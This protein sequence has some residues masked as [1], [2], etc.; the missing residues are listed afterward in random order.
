MGFRIK[1]KERVDAAVRRIVRAQLRRGDPGGARRPTA[2]QEERV[3]EVRTRLKRS[4]AALALIRRRVGKAAD[5]GRSP[6]AR[7]GPP[8]GAAARSGGP[9]AHVSG[10]RDA[11]SRRAAAAPGAAPRAASSDRC[12]A[13][14]RPTEVERE[15]RRYGARVA[16]AAAQ[17]RRVAGRA[18]P[19]RRGGGGDRDLPQGAAG[20]ARRARRG[21]RRGGST[22]G[23]SR[24]RRSRTSCA[25][26]GARFRSWPRRS[27]PKVERL[28]GAAGA[29]ARPRLREG[30]RGAA[31]AL[32]RR[33]G[34]TLQAVLA[35]LDERRAALEAEALALAETVFAGRARD[36][37]A[38]V[39]IGWQLWRHA[40]G[41]PARRTAA[42]APPTGD[43]K[44][45]LD[46]TRE[47]R[48]RRSIGAGR[49]GAAG[50]TCQIA[51]LR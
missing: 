16:A 51:R 24:S 35:L 15:L 12:A 1:R 30:H 42:G 21:R 40:P 29:G 20:A 18:R 10:A 34:A 41:T 2:A 48:P 27:C 44:V 28:G 31:P 7:R 23:A 25:S 22:T 17:P 33:A 14:S 32:V 26:S 19:A 43:P 37:R 13:P 47:E 6:A 5:A 50:R 39:E 36:V 4:R 46:G 49:A 45:A 11:T 8:A 9:G 3:H 38:L